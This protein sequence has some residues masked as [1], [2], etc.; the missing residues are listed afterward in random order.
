MAKNI[1]YHALQDYQHGQH[2]DVQRKNQEWFIQ[3]LLDTNS[4]KEKLTKME[5][6]HLTNI[7]E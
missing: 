3:P 5:D 7:G 6:S 1:I 2:F 4:L